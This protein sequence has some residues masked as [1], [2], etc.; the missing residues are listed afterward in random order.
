MAKLRKLYILLQ[1][2]LIM[3]I[4]LKK[5]FW[6]Q[7]SNGDDPSWLSKSPAMQKNLPP[8]YLQYKNGNVMKRKR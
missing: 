8:L 7:K 4:I 2:M 1:Y 3:Q 5:F 6:E